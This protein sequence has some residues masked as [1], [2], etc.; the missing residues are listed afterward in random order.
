[1]KKGKYFQLFPDEAFELLNLWHDRTS[2][3]T[4]RRFNDLDDILIGTLKKLYLK[5]ARNCQIPV[6]KSNRDIQVQDALASSTDEAVEFIENRLEEFIVDRLECQRLTP[7]E[8]R[9]DI[10]NE[11]THVIKMLAAE[12]LI[13]GIIAG[14]HNLLPLEKDLL[15]ASNN[16]SKLK[17]SAAKSKHDSEIE[18][19]PWIEE[20]NTIITKLLNAPAKAYL[21][22]NKSHVARTVITNLKLTVCTKAVIRKID[23]LF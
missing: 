12:C 15:R 8:L 4:K 5:S 13:A 17:E 3:G 16:I 11:I 18:G 20:A 23:I 9:T 6:D 10:S 21:A 7:K 14:E 19:E 1:M 2:N 22:K